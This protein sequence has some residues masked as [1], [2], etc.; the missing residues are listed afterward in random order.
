MKHRRKL[1]F[2]WFNAIK[3]QRGFVYLILRIISALYLIAVFVRKKIY[4]WKIP[5][6]IKFDN[7]FII[8]VG[9]IT[10]GGTG[11]TPLVEYISHIMT[12]LNISAAIVSRGYGSKSSDDRRVRIV[13]NGK[14]LLLKQIEAGDEP[15]MLAL[16]LKKIPIIV[17]K[18]R[19]K[20]IDAAISMFNSE[21]VILDDGG[22][23]GIGRLKGR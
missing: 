17:D 18:N 9:N 10:V 8:S 7:C 20:A 13:T 23:H 12:E 21:A 1:E 15:Y 11:K 16:K 19:I 5:H 4:D 6:I 2:I 3:T 14:D 22:I